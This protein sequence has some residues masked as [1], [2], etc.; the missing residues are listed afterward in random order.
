MEQLEQARGLV[1]ELKQMS[2]NDQAAIVARRETT[3]EDLIIN[4][5]KIKQR[6]IKK[7]SPKATLVQPLT[8]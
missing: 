4:A 2:T 1:R 5:G 6:P 7:R 8:V 3:I